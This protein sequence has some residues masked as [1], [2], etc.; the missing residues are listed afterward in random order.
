MKLEASQ[1][2]RVKLVTSQAAVDSL[3]V[4]LVISL[5]TDTPLI[6]SN[7]RTD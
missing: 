4:F 1:I 6:P 2:I 5:A 7:P 3:T